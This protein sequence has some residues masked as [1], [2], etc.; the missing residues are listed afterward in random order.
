MEPIGTLA[1][2]TVFFL[3]MNIGI[4][5]SARELL[6][7]TRASGLLIRSLVSVV[8]VVPAVVLVLMLA[9]DLPAGVQ[10]GLALL[11]AC[12]GAPMTTKRAAAASADMVFVSSLQLALALLAVVIA[13]L[14]LAIFY[15]LFD[16]QI[17]RMSPI[18]AAGQI[19]TVAFLP[20]MIGAA[21]RVFAPDLAG[22]LK[23]WVARIGDL[24]FLLLL[25]VLVGSLIFVEEL[26][27]VFIVGWPAALTIAIIAIAALASG[28]LLGGPDRKRRAGL[29]IATVARNIGLA[30]YL[31]DKSDSTYAIV[32]TILVFM[33]TGSVLAMIY[34]AWAKRAVPS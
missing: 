11:A 9:T 17:E 15:A 33:L 10:S 16:L 4:S 25:A 34:S 13:P 3:M 6:P 12:I 18:A 23:N 31:A 14:V 27:Q 30:L 21:I 20:L 2:V 22:W 7:D 19:A 5:N 29:A 26:R 8:I 28:H 32:P 24:L 1:G